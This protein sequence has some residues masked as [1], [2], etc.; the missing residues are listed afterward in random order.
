MNQLMALVDEPETEIA[1][2]QA[3][4]KRLNEVVIKE[5]TT[6][7]SN[8]DLRSKS[9]Q[10]AA[11]MV[12]ETSVPLGDDRPGKTRQIQTAVSYAFLAELES[13]DC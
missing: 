2:S 12:A 7:R 10:R 5:L 8:P 4:A 6:L 9:Y 1:A 11:L 13:S 3:R